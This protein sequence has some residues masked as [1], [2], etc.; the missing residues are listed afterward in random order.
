MLHTLETPQIPAP[1]SDWLQHRP[2][3]PTSARS[4]LAVAM[5]FGRRLAKATVVLIAL[6]IVGGQID[7]VDEMTMLGLIAWMLVLIP[8][9]RPV[10]RPECPVSVHAIAVTG[11][12]DGDVTWQVTYRNGVDG[13]S[14]LAAAVWVGGNFDDDSKAAARAAAQADRDARQ[15]DITALWARRAS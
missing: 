11:P 3:R 1:V 2:N 12:G 13:Q 5:D 10:K 4:S 6:V 7:R 9:K 8:T 14:H 15:A